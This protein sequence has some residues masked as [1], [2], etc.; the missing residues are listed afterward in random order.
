MMTICEKQ[1]ARMVEVRRC[2]ASKVFQLPLNFDVPV[3]ISETRGGCVHV[4]LNHVPFS[5]SW[6]SS[7]IDMIEKIPPTMSAI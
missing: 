6:D 4:A 1:T 7:F 2:E 5:W 3:R